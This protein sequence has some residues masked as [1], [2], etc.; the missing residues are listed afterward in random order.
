M[1]FSFGRAAILA[2][3]IGVAGVVV[4]RAQTTQP[5]PGLDALFDKT[6]SSCH[7][8]PD[9]TRAPDRGALRRISPESIYKALADGPMAPMARAL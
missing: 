7:D 5:E 6:C 2:A 8:H 1:A 4:A 3:T 9:K